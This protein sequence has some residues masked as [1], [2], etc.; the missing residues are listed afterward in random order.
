[1]GDE[2]DEVRDTYIRLNHCNVHHL[3]NAELLEV[4]KVGSQ[5]FLIIGGW[6]RTKWIKRLGKKRDFWRFG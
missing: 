5:P 3:K 1:M 4:L 6:G 2:E